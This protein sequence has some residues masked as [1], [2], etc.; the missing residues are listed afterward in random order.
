MRLLLDTPIFVWALAH[1]DSLKRDIAHALENQANELWLSPITV[2]ETAILAERGRIALD[3][4][5]RQ[6]ISQALSK[7]PFIEAPLNHQVAL[8]SREVMLPHRDPAD[9]FLVATALTYDLVFIT[10]DRTIIDSKAV[11]ILP[12][13]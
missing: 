7:V 13:V 11:A 4:P 12:N 9:R 5:Y 3:R 1:P 10:A 6:W 2:W 8:K